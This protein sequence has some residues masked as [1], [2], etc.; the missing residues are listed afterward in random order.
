MKDSVHNKNRISR[1]GSDEKTAPVQSKHTISFFNATMKCVSSLQ[2]H[3]APRI[4]TKLLFSFTA[5]P[6]STIQTYSSIAAILTIAWRQ[7]HH[8]C[9]SWDPTIHRYTLPSRQ[10]IKKIEELVIE[11]GGNDDDVDVDD[12]DVMANTEEGVEI[13]WVN[14]SFS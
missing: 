2:T 7:R 9:R 4:P 14:K 6:A 5:P 8:H 3:L 11:N 13:A 12:D 1:K 10:P